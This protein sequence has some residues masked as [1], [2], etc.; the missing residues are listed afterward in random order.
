MK[1]KLLHKK[2]RFN[3]YL[4]LFLSLSPLHILELTHTYKLF[5]YLVLS[6]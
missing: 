1:L 2:L 6:L 3:S 5:L 4:S